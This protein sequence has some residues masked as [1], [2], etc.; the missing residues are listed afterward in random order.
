MSFC[1]IK[2]IKS[3]E[4]HLVCLDSTLLTSGQDF[5]LSTEEKNQ[6]TSIYST[7]RQIEFLGVRY[8]K[9]YLFSQAESIHYTPEGIPFLKVHSTQ[10]ISIS[11]SYIY[12]GLITAKFIIGLD[13]EKISEKIYRVR[14][15]FLN[16]SEKDE[17]DTT[18]LETL[19]RIWT[20]KE[21]IYKISHTPGLDYKNDIV[22]SKENNRYLGSVYLQNKWYMTEFHTFVENNYIFSF[23]IKELVQK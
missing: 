18:D 13:I 15:K 8:L 22:I 10:K 3:D 14:D 12:I 20:M 7:K 2:E 5:F 16:Q 17:F 4:F 21:V 1:L 19:T 23:N 9:H 6:L 11:H